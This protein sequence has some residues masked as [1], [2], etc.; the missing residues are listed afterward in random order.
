MRVFIDYKKK[1]I[2]LDV[3]E[4]ITINSLKELVEKECKSFCDDD[5]PKI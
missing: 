3:E 4:T 5:Y 2:P 1:S